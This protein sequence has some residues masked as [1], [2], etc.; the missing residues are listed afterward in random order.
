MAYGVWMATGFVEW[1]KGWHWVSLVLVG[2]MALGLAL[3]AGTL[4]F[5]KE[6]AD[7]PRIERHIEAELGEQIGVGSV[8]V[9]CPS[10]IEWETG[11]D[12]RCVATSGDGSRVMVTVYMEND[13]GDV[14]WVVE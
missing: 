6:P 2:A 10:E 1:V 11:E 3:W 5:G 13:A 9:E 8:S 14:T 7:I 4:L 12:F